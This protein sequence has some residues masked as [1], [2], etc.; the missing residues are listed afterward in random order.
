MYQWPC[1]GSGTNWPIHS[2]DLYQPTGP[3]PFT[4]CSLI[5]LL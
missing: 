3:G 2:C 5:T 4:K 1:P